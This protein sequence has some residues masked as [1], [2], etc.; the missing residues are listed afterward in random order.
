MRGEK[1]AVEVE[2]GP[3]KTTGPVAKSGSCCQGSVETERAH[4]CVTAYE[5]LSVCVC[6]GVGGCV[7]AFAVIMKKSVCALR[8]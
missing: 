7:R 1:S 4:L 6:R 3:L 2:T 8:V 5:C